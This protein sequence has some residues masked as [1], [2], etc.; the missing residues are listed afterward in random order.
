MRVLTMTWLIGIVSAMIL[1]ACVVASPAAPAEPDMMD[2]AGP[3]GPVTLR[4][5]AITDDDQLNA[6]REILD[7][8]Q[9]LNDGEYSYVEIEFE[10]V[11]FRELFP[12]IES[13]VAVGLP[14]DLF[15]ADGP[16]MKHYGFNRV[17]TPL[18]DYFS[19]EEMSQWF[20]QSIEEGSF[21]DEFLGPPIMQSC[22][23]MMYNRDMTDAAGISP[24][25]SVSDGWTMDEAMAAWEDTTVDE[26]GD[27]VPEVWGVRWGQ[28]TWTG[29]YEH[30]IFR[31]SN[32]AV[33]SPTYAGMGEDGISFRGYLDTPEA[34]EAM[35]FYQDMHLTNKVTP[36]EP[37]PEI[38]ESRQSAFMITPD[39]RIGALNR[40]H[41]ED[42]FNWGVT[43]I[44]YFQSQVC[45]TGSWHYGISP[46]TEHFEEALAF[47][48]YASS[49]AGARIWYR[50]VRQLPA[51]IGLFNELDEYSEEGSQRIW[52]DAMNTFG[53]PR[54]QTPGYTEYQQLFA[55]AAGNITF[56]ADPQ[57]QLS[58][59]AR[60]IEGLVAK[61]AGWN[62]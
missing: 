11:P 41:G 8:F 35:Q 6:W 42:G 45:H 29:D 17:I 58:A 21:R 2:D 47:V 39:N 49:D 23:L 12:K 52:L 37:I 14:W 40:I 3:S 48:R 24:P 57:E 13:S 7:A 34:V 54:I 38:F 50:H 10:T 1:A 61:Y 16:D 9:Q 30:G 19:E 31:R 62:E 43:S 36:V 46:N 28:G 56:G 25:G 20:P 5:L 26:N 27:G 55:E 18:T 22:S 53:I 32:G 51:N 15:Q 60:R 59:A 33:G 4:F 44:P